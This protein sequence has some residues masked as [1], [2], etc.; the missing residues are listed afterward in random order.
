MFIDFFGNETSV[1][2]VSSRDLTKS[3][4]LFFVILQ[5]VFMFL[6]VL[7]LKLSFCADRYSDINEGGQLN[8][9]I[10]LSYFLLFSTQTIFC[11][12]SKAMNVS[13][14]NE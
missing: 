2:F 12:R 8:S 9:I 5:L 14:G 6:S 1:N 7:S 13:K 11:K 10:V 4:M 3:L